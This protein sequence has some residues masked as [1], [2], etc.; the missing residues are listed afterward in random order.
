ME[1]SYIKWYFALTNLTS[2]INSV[3]QKVS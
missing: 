3:L 1:E 2:A